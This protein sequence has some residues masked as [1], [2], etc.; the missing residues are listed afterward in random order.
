MKKNATRE[1]SS[2]LK[3]WLQ[4]HKDNPYPSKGEKILLAILTQMTLTQVSTWFANARRRLKK[5]N[6]VNWL[7]NEKSEIRDSGSDSVLSDQL[8]PEYEKPSSNQIK[9]QK[10]QIWSIIDMISESSDRVP[11]EF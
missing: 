5:E 6:K 8:M 9:V 3:A 10:S 4:E 1:N 11:G 7:I 2:T